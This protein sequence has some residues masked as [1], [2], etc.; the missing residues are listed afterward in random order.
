MDADI[1]AW[2]A[3]DPD[4]VTRGE[5]EALVTAAD[6]AALAERFAGRLG[7]GTAGLR[8]ILGAGPSRMNRLVVQ[9]TS[10]GLGAYL[11]TQVPDACQ[12]GVVIGFDGRHNSRI[13][14]ADT[15][16]VLAA[17]GFQV[18]LFEHEEPTPV[19]GYT[20][21]DRRAAAGV[22]ITASHNPP[23]YNGYKVYWENGAQI[24][25]PHDRG[26]ATAIDAA[27]QLP[28][29][30]PL[31]PLPELAAAGQLERLGA[32]QEQRYLDAIGTL[33]I[34]RRDPAR[35]HLILAYTPLHGVGARL[36][37]A[38]L[39]RAGFTQV[40]TVASQRQP[41]GDFPTVRFPNPEEPG[42]MDAVL[43]LAAQ[44]GADLAFANDPDADRLAVAVRRADGSY[45]NLSGD[46]IG[47]LLAA[48]RLERAPARAVVATTIVSSRL[49]A[50][51]AQAHGVHYFETLTG[52]KWLAN[53]CLRAAEAGMVPLIAYEEALGY[54]IGDVVW[55]KDGISALLAFAEYAAA[56]AAAGSHPLA[57]LDTLYRTH[58]LSLT[59]QWTKHLPASN[60][61]PWSTLLRRHPPTQMGGRAIVSYRDLLQPEAGV[62]A[63]PLPSSDVLIY[64]LAG[65]ARII[66]RPSG[67]EPKIK[68]YY[69]ICASSTVDEPLQQ[70]E[71]RARAEL[72]TLMDHHRREMEAL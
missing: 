71:T 33:S 72:A 7:F 25:P 29:P 59:A 15:A 61:H 56:C 27:A 18:A 20:V 40:H 69:E 10:A 23:A 3:R 24:I 36:T 55:D 26:I 21:R 52:F 70:V 57:R 38:A 19:I 2:L 58:G 64:S 42:S 17:L 30:S 51:M 8:G 5:L 28:L 41:D 48:D 43:A 62:P 65:D 6:H 44:V 68:C 50:R 11:R 16:Q 4:A 46:E 34:H 13:F 63:H 45:R 35:A 9:E 37:E 39:A 54:A 67:T 60:A 32:A 66:V 12:R 47:I 31:R 22:V 1:T 49:L 53:G 14:A